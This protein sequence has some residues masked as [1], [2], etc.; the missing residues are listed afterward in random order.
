M[1]CKHLNVVERIGE[2]IFYHVCCFNM[3]YITIVFWVAVLS[4]SFLIR[5]ILLGKIW[6]GGCVGCVVCGFVRLSVCPLL[7]LSL[8]L[9]LRLHLS[10]GR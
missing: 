4:C 8:I 6:H 9:N 10:E 3:R 2:F 7:Q 5:Y 1:W